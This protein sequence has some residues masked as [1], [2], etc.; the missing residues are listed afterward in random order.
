MGR[1]QKYT[2]NENYFN[3]ID[4]ENKAYI[5]GF[6]YADGSV[7][8]KGY[9]LTISLSLKDISILEFIKREISFGGP[10]ARYIVN[11]REY[12]RITV[13]SKTI[14]DDLVRYGIVPNKT[15]SSSSLP[16]CPDKYYKNMILGFF[17]GDGCIYKSNNE[18]MLA[19]AS[20]KY[21]LLQ[22]KEWLLK[23]DIRTANIRHRYS[24]D[25]IFAC[26]LEMH[27]GINIENV[28]RLLYDTTSF[29]LSRKYDIFLE[30]LNSRKN[31]KRKYSED[32]VNN[33]IKLH[34]ENLSYRQISKQLNIPN[35]SVKT[36]IR[37]N[38]IANK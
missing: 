31:I 32:I 16:L 17:D 9:Y 14:K 4:N 18:Y 24:T 7:S 2:L 10:I 38:R 8:T 37:K 13:S 1:P 12:C 26:M 20:N 5:L 6:I 19:F 28:G 21:V 27:G 15:Y 25:N 11:D 23:N 34:T 30:F 35:N 36:I 22:I 33:I 3:T 29:R